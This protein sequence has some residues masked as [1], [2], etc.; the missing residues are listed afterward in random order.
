MRKRLDEA[1]KRNGFVVPLLTGRNAMP[2]MFQQSFS[3]GSED[4]AIVCVDQIA[5]G[6]HETPGA[7][8]WLETAAKSAR[9]TRQGQRA[10]DEKRKH[11]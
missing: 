9:R 3:P 11:P 8:E 1:Q 7:V 2:P 6:W 10:Q 4:E 5:G